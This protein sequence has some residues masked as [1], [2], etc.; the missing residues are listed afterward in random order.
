MRLEP[1]SAFPTTAAWQD[2]NV[3]DGLKSG[4]ISIRNVFII[5]KG[6]VGVI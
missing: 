6:R 5:A 4:Y 1:V 3:V 2:A